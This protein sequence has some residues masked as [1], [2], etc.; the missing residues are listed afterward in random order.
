[1]AHEVVSRVEE[2]AGRLAAVADETERLGKL[3]DESV[4][5]I[6][7]A[8]VMRLLQPTDFGGYAAHP[9]DFAEAVM[10]VA[11]ACGSTGWVCGVGGVHPWEM[12]LCDRKL[13]QEVWGSDPNTWIASPYM[14]SGVATPTDGGYILKGRWQFSSGTDHCD[15]IFLGA[16]LGDAEGRPAQPMKAMHVV[17][18]RSDYT[19][20][21]D[22]W[23]V[24]GLR[25]TGSK[26]VIVDGAFIPAYRTIDAEEVAAGD[27][28][29]ERAGRTETVYRLPFWSMFPLGIT[30]AV[31]GICE[32][33]LAAHLDYQRD[34]VMA[35]GTK[36][37]DDPYTLFAISEAASEIQ[38]SRLQLLDGISRLYDL[39]DSGKPITFEDRAVVRRNQI[40][41]AW[42]AVS[43]VDEIFA[44]S[45][46]NAVRRGNPMQRFWRDAHVGLQHAIHIPGSA[47]HATAQIQMGVEPQ[48]ALRLMI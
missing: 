29:A 13:Q 7:E 48:G 1:M 35:A 43:A 23:D 32:G 17:L 5:L 21:E 46:G 36:V 18:P 12:A 26:D 14:P 16:L 30:S 25:G 42:R 47:Y 8:G 11:K 9:R 2:I 3:A 6:R 39:A 31:V 4:K 33:A 22:S 19:I 44:R 27:L 24:I 34:R 41:C 38:A 10:A 28:A 45:G 15:W 37:K 20:V 40:R